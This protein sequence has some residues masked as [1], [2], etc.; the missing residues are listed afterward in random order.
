MDNERPI[1]RLL[2]DYAKKR[3]ADGGKSLEMHPATRRLLQGEVARQFPRT[4]RG[5]FSL[6]GFFARWKP[7]LVY[8][9][10]ALALVAVSV[11]L[12]LSTFRTAGP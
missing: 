8:A 10:C 3:R 5:G 12:M 1:E 4:H 6:S 2:R 7:G 11:P 9:L